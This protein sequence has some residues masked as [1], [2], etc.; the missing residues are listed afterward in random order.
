MTNPPTE[1]WFVVVTGP[2]ASGKTAFVASAGEAVPDAEIV[3][4][5]VPD[6]AEMFSH[7][8]RYG[9]HI[10]TDDETLYLLATPVSRRFDFMW[11]AIASGRMIGFVVMLDSRKP[12]EF[13]EA[14]SILETF[15]AY[16][17]GPYVIAANF[18]DSA[19]AWDAETLRHVMRLPDEIP[20]VPCI[21]TQKESVK[22]V[23]IALLEK[24]IEA[25]DA[26][27]ELDET[28][29]TARDNT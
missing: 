8:I 2:F 9:S 15:R 20:V 4:P 11:E 16:A 10:Q 22:G 29:I 19:D 21:A 17:P 1:Y 18:Q 6:N 23:L 13:R 5:N 12:T 25:I 24:V 3:L 27:E 26:P 28:E 7:S 14:K